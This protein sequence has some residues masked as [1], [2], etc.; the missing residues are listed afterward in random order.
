M[1]TGCEEN[2]CLHCYS[3]TVLEE[4]AAF[5]TDCG[6]LQSREDI[7]PSINGLG[8]DQPFIDGLNF[9]PDYSKRSSHY[10]EFIAKISSISNSL[11]LPESAIGQIRSL[12]D[13]LWFEKNL[14]RRTPSSAKIAACI[15]LV[16]RNN[17]ELQ[18]SL[19]DLIST[20][21]TTVTAMRKCFNAAKE[22][23]YLEPF[24]VYKVEDMIDRLSAY[25]SEND[26]RKLADLALAIDRLTCIRYERGTRATIGV[27]LIIIAACVLE[28][29]YN[30][31]Q[32]CKHFEVSITSVYPLSS[33][34]RKRMLKYSENI[35]WRPR[36]LTEKN[37]TKFGQEIVKFFEEFGKAEDEEKEVDVAEKIK[38]A[39]EELNGVRSEETATKKAKR[40][41]KRGNNNTRTY[42][43]QKIEAKDPYV[44]LIKELIQKGCSQEELHTGKIISLSKKYLDW[45]EHDLE[46]GD[47]DISDGEIA[48]YLKSDDELGY[49]YQLKKETD[50]LFSETE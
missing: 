33:I 46:Q 42:K 19:K 41:R 11:N 45:T 12:S 6:A 8:H 43:K 15:Y 7:F 20:C 39:L 9:C 48:Q 13:Q 28:I 47:D 5:C 36:N 22:V 35:P 34:C 29:K 50:P 24:P 17:P 2:I 3:N 49:V 4:D 18:T 31:M 25:V 30:T 21:N 32:I 27:S 1:A 38:I 14:K 40:I 44:L 26:S 37:V 16:T 10:Q 23:M